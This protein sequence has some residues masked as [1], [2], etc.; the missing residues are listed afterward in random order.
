MKKIMISVLSFLCCCILL[1]AS[2]FAGKE[3]YSLTAAEVVVD[4]EHN[5]A[6]EVSFI[7]VG[8]GRY[9]ALQG[10]WSVHEEGDTQFFTLTELKP[11]T[12]G[13]PAMESNPQTGS[14]IWMDMSFTS[15]IVAI[16]GGTIWSALYTV[17]KDTPTGDYT[18]RF[19]VTDIS[20]IR[21]DDT[22]VGEL[23]IKIKV[24]NNATPLI[25]DVNG[26]NR[27]DLQDVLELFRRVSDVS[28]ADDPTVCDI[29]GDGRVSN[30]DA[31]T[32]FRRLAN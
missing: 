17:D 19:T 22:S 13:P 8:G 23:E 18:L 26:D 30:R 3:D 20:D 21:S 7:S 12:E 4:G 31:I 1:S 14:V 29:N 16:E 10:K 25:G 11:G 27:V 6:V 2:G 24:K 5:Q 32:L 28:V 15:P 9:Y